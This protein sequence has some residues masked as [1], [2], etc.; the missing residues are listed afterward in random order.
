MK[1]KLNF[2]LMDHSRHFHGLRITSDVLA[3]ADIVTAG[4]MSKKRRGKYLF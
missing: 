2:S 4:R 1:T 3:E